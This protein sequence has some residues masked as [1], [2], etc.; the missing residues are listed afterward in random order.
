M[1]PDTEVTNCWLDPHGEP[2]PAPKHH[3]GI[4][5]RKILGLSPQCDTD[6]AF[7]AL[8]DLGYA[9][10]QWESN[11]RVNVAY[12]YLLPA[13]EAKLIDLIDILIHSGFTVMI[14][15]PGDT[16]YIRQGDRRWKQNL[17]ATREHHNEAVGA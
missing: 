1:T 16:L 15:C 10:V 8:Y 2:H 6:E 3:H 9:R 14:A 7:R 11:R 12:R 17:R 4:E 13:V 5:A